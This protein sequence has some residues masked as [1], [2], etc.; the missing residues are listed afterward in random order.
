VN[1]WNWKNRWYNAHGFGWG[2]QHWDVLIPAIFA[3]RDILL[4]TVAEAGVTFA[5]GWDWNTQQAAMV[6]IGQGIVRFGQKLSGGLAHVKAL[7][8]GGAA[9][10]HVAATPWYCLGAPACALPPGTH[11]VYYSTTFLQESSAAWIAMITV[12]EPAHVIDWHSR[13][14][15]GVV[16]P[17]AW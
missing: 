7:L 17:I 3:D 11:N 16:I 4:E 2:G 14:Q 1:E 13:I 8:G 10:H 9:L 6:A 15:I 5:S 12:H